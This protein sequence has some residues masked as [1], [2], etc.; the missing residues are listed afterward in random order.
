MTP[1][2]WA[3]LI[4]L[5]ANAAAIVYSM[6]RLGKKVAESHDLVN[7]RMTQLIEEVRA[8]GVAQG[9]QQ[10]REESQRRTQE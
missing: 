7:G 2:D 6:R 8:A 9:L 5:L 1:G 3:L 10:G 4:G